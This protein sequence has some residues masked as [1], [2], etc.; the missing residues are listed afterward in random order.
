MGWYYGHR[1]PG[2]TTR[3]YFEREFPSIE[4]VAISSKMGVTFA[5]CRTPEK[6]DQVWA[7]VAL[8]C[9]QPRSEYNFGYKSM[10]ETMEP[11]ED[12]CPASILD[13]LT[14]TTNEHARTWRA[15][16]RAWLEQCAIS[17]TIT[18]GT[19]IRFDK[20]LEFTDGCKG[21]VF[22]KCAKRNTFWR[23]SPLDFTPQIG[24][25]EYVAATVRIARWQDRKY[26]IEP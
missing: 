20:Q 9:W 16:C 15:R 26:T 14:P 21:D 10:D 18:E 23:M 25:P 5:A 24:R 17:A 7:L 2:M 8:T 11:A 19:R 1:E 6:P 3:A 22:V 4:I 12:R 13:L